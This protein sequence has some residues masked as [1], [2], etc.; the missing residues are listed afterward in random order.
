M[1]LH[2]KI[3]GLFK[4]TTVAGVVSSLFLPLISLAKEPAISEVSLPGAPSLRGS[5]I[6]EHALWVTGSNNAVFVSFDEG[7]SWLDRSP[8]ITQKSDFRDVEAFS[9]KHAIVMAV[10]SG[11]ASKL[12]E[13]KDGGKNWSLLYQNVHEQGFFDSIAFWSEKV[14][15][16]MGDP[17]DGY[18]VVEKT[19]DGGKT[20][21]RIAKAKLPKILN[22]EAAFAASGHTLI[23]GQNGKA[24]ITTGGFS[25]SVYVSDDFGE[26][27]QRQSVP[28]FD[29]TQTAGGYGLAL[30][31]NQQLFVMGGDYQQRPKSY[32]N[33]AMYDEGRWH[34]IDARNRGLRTAM[35]CQ[36]NICLTTGKTGSDISFNHGHTWQPFDAS[37]DKKG[38][39]GFYTVTGGQGIFLT[40][41]AEG[42]VGVVRLKK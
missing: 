26:S 12:L 32:T 2:A 33:L 21:R 30:N 4:I 34:V 8:D 6:V 23:V 7:H 22:Q 42:R 14:G 39:K 19:E 25:A 31:S 29:D 36:Q 16:L 27:W 9:N 17:V 15:L 18:Y 1:K 24:Y 28:I 20:W 11:E 10:G 35:S 3:S 37:P 5:A 38:D 40:A 13:T 41:G